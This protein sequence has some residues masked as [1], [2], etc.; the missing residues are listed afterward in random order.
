MSFDL[1]TTYLVACFVIVI[2]PGPTVTLIVANSLW[3]GTRA[4]PLQ[5]G[6]PPDGIRSGPALECAQA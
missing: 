1:Y 3:H 6:R 2:V 4:G 5:R